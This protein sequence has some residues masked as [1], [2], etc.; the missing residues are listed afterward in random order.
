MASCHNAPSSYRPATTLSH[1]L[2]F[3]TSPDVW[4]YF[5]VKSGGGIHE[6]SD[7]QARRAPWP[8]VK[9]PTA[10]YGAGGAVMFHLIPPP[11]NTDP[12]HHFSTLSSSFISR[13]L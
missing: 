10:S 5:S 8:A 3:R 6:F 11:G 4:G 7:A 2:S 1:E 12:C 13:S 9:I